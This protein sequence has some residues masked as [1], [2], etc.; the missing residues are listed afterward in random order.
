MSD[1]RKTAIITGGSRGIGRAIALQL[2]EEADHIAVFYAGR[3]DAADETVAQ[4][5]AL[6]AE[7]MALQ[8]DVADPRQVKDCVARVRERFGPVSILV[9]NAGITLDGLTLRMT[10]EAFDR[11]LQV[12]LAGAFHTIQ[13]CYRDL[14]KSGWGRVVNI[15]SVSGLMGN[16]GQA[17]YAAAKAGLVGLTKTIARE[18]APRGVTVN[19]VAPG[20]I[21]TDMTRDMNPE[22]LTQAVSQVPMRR[23][24]TP[25]DIAQAVRFLCSPGADYVTGCV[26]Q[27]DGG[28]YM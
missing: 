22:T 18:L 13:A 5:N 19:A 23:A 21:D 15:T 17:N 25:Q 1:M 26:L 6:G 11:V 10:P 24:G 12:N 8:C 14:M 9:N 2:A 7:A 28:L 27:V 20:Y 16:P 3:K 4:L